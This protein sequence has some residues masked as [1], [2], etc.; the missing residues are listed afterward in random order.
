MSDV[1]CHTQRNCCRNRLSSL[2]LPLRRRFLRGR[3]QPSKGSACHAPR[4]GSVK[5]DSR[6]L[7]LPESALA[8]HQ[9]AKNREAT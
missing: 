9:T 4:I 3:Y 2:E 5:K 1:G 6:P 7:Y 8:K